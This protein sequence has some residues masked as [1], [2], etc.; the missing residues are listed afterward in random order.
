VQSAGAVGRCVGH[1]GEQADQPGLAVGQFDHPGGAE[2]ERVAPQ[3]GRRRS[4]TDHE[5]VITPGEAELAAAS[6]AVAVE[7]HQWRAGPVQ[8]GRG[9]VRY[10]LHRASGRGR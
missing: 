6:H 4:G 3:V 8:A 9:G 7:E 2:F 1:V 10:P 5:Y